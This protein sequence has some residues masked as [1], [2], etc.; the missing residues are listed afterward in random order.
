MDDKV[1]YWDGITLDLSTV[2]LVDKKNSQA[3]LANGV[4]LHR[5][6]D[7]DGIYHRSD[8][9]ESLEQR[10]SKRRKGKK[11]VTNLPVTYI[12]SAWLYGT[13]NT[14]K[15]WEAR[16]AKSFIL[17]TLNLLKPSVDVKNKYLLENEELVQYILE[18]QKLA[19]KMKDKL[20]E[21]NKK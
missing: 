21:F 14:E 1:L 8:Y 18:I 3:K 16:L 5:T 7:E 11:S 20:N 2:V 12:S 15:I 4:M 17:Q 13:G 10:E 6:P 9:K 19:K